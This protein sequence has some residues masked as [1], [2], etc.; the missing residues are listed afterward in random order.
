M[1]EQC[2]SSVTNLG[3]EVLILNQL[4][5]NTKIKLKVYSGIV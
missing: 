1:Q 4:N 2:L 5:L 3:E